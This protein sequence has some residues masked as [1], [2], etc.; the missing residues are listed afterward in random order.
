MSYFFKIAPKKVILILTPPKGLHEAPPKPQ[1][2]EYYGVVHFG[3]NKRN[4][5]SLLRKPTDPRSKG[6]ITRPPGSLMR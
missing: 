1:F 2:K 5:S 3:Q 6:L 4:V